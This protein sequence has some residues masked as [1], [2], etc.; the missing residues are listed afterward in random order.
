MGVPRRK[1]V[2]ALCAFTLVGVFTGSVWRLR[3]Q[4]PS[5][6]RP[7]VQTL[8]DRLKAAPVT[9]GNRG[10][11][12]H[13]LERQA[14]HVKTTFR[15]AVIEAERAADGQL[16][17]RVLDLAGN[18]LGSLRVH[19]IDADND[20]LEFASVGGAPLRAAKR[21]NLR[22]TLDWTSAQAYSLW[23]DRTALQTAG[24]LEW[25]DSLMRPKGAA[26]RDVKTEILRIDTEF[27]NGFSAS[28]TRKTA[29]HVSYLTNRQTTGVVF[30]GVLRQDEAEV[31][32]SQWWPAEQAFAWSFPGLTA[33][34]YV[35]AERLQ[36]Y[37]GWTFTP[38]MAWLNVQ[39]LGLQQFGAILKAN[40]KVA[41][42]QNWFDRLAR[43]I[44]PTVQANEPGCDTQHWLDGSILRWCCDV[45]DF[46]YQSYSCTASSWWVWNWWNSWQCDLC[47][48][49]VVYCFY[50]GGAGHVIYRLP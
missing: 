9:D 29:T 43:L 45:H 19:P 40:G 11:T 38:D 26:P 27:Q 23:N 47:N 33:G 13:T 36:S 8:K 31:G 3:A 32:F 49:D 7:P 15:N 22:P 6:A 50:S 4:V 35:T 34:G 1:F 14:V 25:Q 42:R 18:E 24:G 5:T 17:A 12:Y 37:G 44:S 2:A 30:Q 28:V 48:I 16:S 46:C 21:A 41:R 10:A 39:N 20:M